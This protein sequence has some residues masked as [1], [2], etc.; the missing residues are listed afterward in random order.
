MIEA[1]STVV[2]RPGVGMLRLFRAMQYK[3]WYAVGE[4]VDNALQSWRANTAALEA[5]NGG[6]FDLRIDVELD[7]AGGTIVVTDNA[8]GIATADIGRAFTPAAPPADASGLSQFGVGMKSAACW[9]GDRFEVTT[10]ALGEPVR[11]RVVFDVTEI[12]SSASEHVP[13]YEAPA[14]ASEHGTVLVL[15]NLHQ[16]VPTGRTLGKIREYLASIYRSFLIEERVHL[17]VGGVPL[18]APAT[19]LLVAP[20][21]D[22]PNGPHL[23]WRKH[24]SMTLPSGRTVTGWAGNFAKGANK[25]AGFALLYRGKVVQGAGGMAGEPADSYRPAEIF[26]TGN[27]FESQRIVG[28]LDVSAIPVS[29]TKNALLWDGDEE[30]ALIEALAAQLD[31]EPLPLLR[32]ARGYRATERGRGIQH[33]VED[34]L[35]KVAHD[36]DAQSARPLA[37]YVPPTPDRTVPPASQPVEKTAQLDVLGERLSIRVVDEPGDR[38]RWLRVDQHGTD[39]SVTVNRAHR[40]MESFANLPGADLEPVMRLAVAFALA[41]IAAERSGA[42]EPRYQLMELNRVLDGQLAERIVT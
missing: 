12:T 16:P 39:W 22:S 42:T 24:V 28:E 4:F 7:R 9:Y 38:R 36:I 40:F 2:V 13:V 20:R 30:Q 25:K 31:A 29:H 17:T 35:I 10:T 26:G 1:P 21:W 37:D 5:A 32:M 41:Q 3:P 14:S 8:A 15:R 34:V 33:A 6:R 19:E 27:T 18:Q 23:T 11:R